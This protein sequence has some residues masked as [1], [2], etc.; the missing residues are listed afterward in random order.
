MRGESM[1]DDSVVGA[2]DLEFFGPSPWGPAID[3]PR[4]MAKTPVEQRCLYCNESI[5]DDD[6]GII[7]GYLT[8]D[9]P[10]RVPEHRECLLRHI[11]G[12]VGHQLG[13]CSCHGGTEE[14]PPGMTKREAARAAVRLFEEAALREHETPRGD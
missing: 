5:A 11:F 7:M 4:R 9:G 8:V 2:L 14:D 6:S 3:E 13:T 1:S 10:R 12:S